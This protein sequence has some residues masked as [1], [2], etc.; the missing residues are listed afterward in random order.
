MSATIY[1]SV[2]GGIEIVRVL[3][4]ARDIENI[5][6]EE[7]GIEEDAGDDETGEPET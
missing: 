2:A 6:A 3:R 5:L 1:R 7:F 4:G